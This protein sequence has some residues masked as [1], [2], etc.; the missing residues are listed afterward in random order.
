MRGKETDLQVAEL[1]KSPEDED[2]PWAPRTPSPRLIAST[3]SRRSREGRGDLRWPGELIER[4]TDMRLRAE[5]RPGQLLPA[6]ADNRSKGWNEVGKETGQ[7]ETILQLRT[8]WNP[9][10]FLRVLRML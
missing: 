3:A 10:F 6:M 2:A 5:R 9:E 7:Y 4:P 8:E 1:I